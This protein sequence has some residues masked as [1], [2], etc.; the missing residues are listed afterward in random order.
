MIEILTVVFA[1]IVAGSSM[2][3]AG[4]AIKLWRATNAS[5]DIARFNAFLGFVLQLQVAAKEAALTSPQDAQILNQ[6]G[7]II[8]EAGLTSMAADVDL[9]K[10]PDL[11]RVI[12][13]LESLVAAQGIDPRSAPVIG[14]LFEKL[15]RE[16]K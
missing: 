8:I 16:V 3:Y 6:L 9:R 15:R 5:V 2:I 7:A 14:G 12:S 1:G 11:V 4:Y 10:N 13:Q